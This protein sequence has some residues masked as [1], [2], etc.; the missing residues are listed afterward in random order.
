MNE[1]FFYLF[2]LFCDAVFFVCL[3]VLLLFEFVVIGIGMENMERALDVRN[4][5]AH[6]L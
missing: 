2:F 4:E 5:I 3:F 6:L 1:G